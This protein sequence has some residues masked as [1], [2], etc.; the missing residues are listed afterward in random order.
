MTP[1]FRFTFFHSVV[2][3][4]GTIVK[5]PVGWKESALSLERDAVWHSL[6]EYFKGTFVWIGTARTFLNNIKETYGPDELV[7]VQ[8]EINYGDAWETLFDG[9]VDISQSVDI[10]KNGKFYKLQ[11]PI[12]RDDFW[13]K[14]MSRKSI[15]VDLT[16]SVDL[17]GNART[18]VNPITL[19][20]PSQKMRARFERLIDWADNV[21]R[22]LDETAVISYPVAGLTKIYILFS[23]ANLVVDE[24]EDRAEY[25]S[26]LSD[27]KPTDVFKY[28]ITA[29]YA[30]SYT[31]NASLKYFFSLS[32]SRTYDVKWYRA[33]RSNGSLTET[34]IGSTQSGTGATI[35]DDGA[36]VL[37]L[38][39][40]LNTGDEFYLWGE[41]DLSS[42]VATAS[43]F[44]D[45]DSD[46]GA[47][48][49]PV[50]TEFEIE[51]D[52]VFIETQTNAYK[53][54]DAAESILSKIIG[55]DNVLIS[56]KL[57]TCAGYNAVAKGIHIRGNSMT[58]K[59]PFMSLDEWWAGVNPLYCFGLGYDGTNIEIEAREDFY[60]KIPVLYFSAAANIEKKVHLD[61]YYKSVEIGFEKWS[62]ESESG[63]DDPQTKKTYATPF[64]SIG[65]DEKV[66]SKFI[67]ASLAIEQTR[68][69]RVEAGKDWRLDEDW[70]LIAL[71]SDDSVETGAD[72]DSITGLLNSDS[73]YN[74]R[75]GVARI[76]TRWQKWFQGCLQNKVGQ[77]FKFTKG[78]GNYEMVSTNPSGDCEPILTLA[79][80]QDIEIT[81]DFIHLGDE[82]KVTLPMRYASYKIV[83]SNRK[84]AVAIPIDGQWFA[85]HILNLDFKIMGGICEANVL[86]ADE[87]PLESINIIQESGEAIITEDG[88]YIIYE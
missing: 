74:V 9:L 72:F 78:E 36:R 42:A 50:Y 6:V 51:S 52:T 37:S 59:K 43:Y 15:P 1:Q 25:G 44:P 66:L 10:S 28:Q 85:C 4:S 2:S 58:T 34:Q 87:T 84:K 65:K 41:L 61:K 56:N 67:G 70:L 49:S 47:G 26:Q 81:D 48:Y 88:N 21:T 22:T 7:R 68:R 38:T 83:N 16:A 71:K 54:K 60:N 24:V 64:K 57:D 14:F 63:V 33:I 46:L 86:L 53:I 18:A 62:A 19:D 8:I 75:H 5:E 12:I 13:T 3:P 77:D 40:Y 55:Q 29:K 69:N 20:L 80:D 45:Y 35:M 76:F 17:D 27:L 32:S 23:N 73:R 31:F 39:T 82:F 30:G 79:E 11:A